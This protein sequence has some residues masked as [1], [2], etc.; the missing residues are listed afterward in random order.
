MEII[1]KTEVGSRTVYYYL[2]VG[3]QTRGE[4]FQERWSNP[5]FLVALIRF[6][7]GKFR[8]QMEGESS[9]STNQI[10][11]WDPVK[12]GTEVVIE[13]LIPPELGGLEEF[14]VSKNC[15]TNPLFLGAVVVGD[16]SYGQPDVATILTT[17]NKKEFFKANPPTIEYLQGLVRLLSQVRDASL[18]GY[19][20]IMIDLFPEDIA[21]DMMAVVRIDPKYWYY[22]KEDEVEGVVEEPEEPLNKRVKI[23]S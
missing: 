16:T 5:E 12:R 2:G 20:N 22:W 3:K 23:S 18:G 19:N 14:V 13:N 4:F 17:L 6:L 21:K 8:E 9:H 15:R 7:V 10:K 11:I 1:N